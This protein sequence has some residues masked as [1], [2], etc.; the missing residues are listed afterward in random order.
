MA[1]WVLVDRLTGAFFPADCGSGWCAQ[2]GVRRVRTRARLLTQRIAEVD[3]ARLVTLT[4]CPDD[5][6]RRRGQVRDLRRRI[7]AAGFRTE[8]AW[9]TEAGHKTG[10]VHV[11][12]IQWGDY[13]PQA[14]L[15]TL[16]GGRIVD[17]RSAVGRHGKYI[18]KAGA[19][20]A[21]YVSKGGVGHLDEALT[22]NG[23]RLHH[24][25]R[26]FWGAPIAS[27][28]QDHRAPGARDWVL[29]FNPAAARSAG[30][31]VPDSMLTLS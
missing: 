18:S 13:I 10:M 14:T 27:Y 15:Q 5:W 7:I 21:N 26:A 25:S 6:Q 3:R 30:S 11:H 19:A 12:A 1:G 8:W 4:N 9:T 17:I 22:L 24:W 31:D 16:W 2:C 20:V 28:E 29:T 23:G